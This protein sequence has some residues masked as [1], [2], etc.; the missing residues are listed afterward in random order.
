MQELALTMAADCIDAQEPEFARLVKRAKAGDTAAFEAI[1]VRYERQVLLTALR[2]LN[3]N[4]EDAKDAAQQVFLRLHRSLGQLDESR[5]FASWLYRITV[6]VCR[7]VQRAR[8]RRPTAPLE[9][10][11][12]PAVSESVEETLRKREQM[13]MIY[14]AL[15]TLP[16]RERAAIALR[17]LEGLETKEVARI[18]G[19]SEVT[20]RSQISNGRVKIRNFVKRRQK[21]VS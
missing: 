2:L 7:D 14:A 17:D 10:A 13:R 8:A 5:H 20:V 16:E 15:A 19:C 4:L 1:L 18:L 3:R 11:G 12:E 9:E 6:N 21:G